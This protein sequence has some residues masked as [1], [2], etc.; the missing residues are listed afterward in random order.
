MSGSFRAY[1]PGAS[2]SFRS[3]NQDIP[4]S[5]LKVIGGGGGGPSF[6]DPNRPQPNQENHRP[7]PAGRD[8]EHMSPVN[9]YMPPNYQ[10]EPG[11][12]VNTSLRSFF[13]ADCRL[14]QERMKLQMS[15]KLAS[16]RVS[17]LPRQRD[18]LV[19][20]REKEREYLLYG[21]MNGTTALDSADAHARATRDR[22]RGD[23]ESRYMLLATGAGG[24]RG[25]SDY[26][27]LP[28]PHTELDANLLTAAEK[29]AKQNEMESVGVQVGKRPTAG[30]GQ[31]HNYMTVSHGEGGSNPEVGA[32]MKRAIFS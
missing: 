32:R 20:E 26:R 9:P 1:P 2:A 15:R 6:S 11:G 17:L 25:N 3:G 10:E 30:V 16:P 22:E 31:Q 18:V 13:E 29:L 24:N 19:R 27:R 4:A 28:G 14:S 12:T 5:I 21:S 7:N 23:L 8:V